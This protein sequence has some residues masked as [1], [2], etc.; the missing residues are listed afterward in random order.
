MKNSSSKVIF[1]AS[2]PFVFAAP[3]GS[4]RLPPKH[5][6]TPIR[7]GGT[8]SKEGL[9]RWKKPEIWHLMVEGDIWWK[10]LNKQEVGVQYLDADNFVNL[11]IFNEFLISLE[12]SIHF[13]QFNI[14]HLTSCGFFLHLWKALASASLKARTAART[15]LFSSESVNE[16]HPDKLCDQVGWKGRR[17][18]MMEEWDEMVLG[19]VVSCNFNLIC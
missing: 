16:G 11:L 14:P 4:N 1:S 5:R 13:N 2:R 12:D 7:H 15:F 17:N 18:R 9:K 6:S 3:I 10:N 19:W 8:C